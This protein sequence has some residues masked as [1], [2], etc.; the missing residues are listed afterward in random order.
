MQL[1][2]S[3]AFGEVCESWEKADESISLCKDTSQNLDADTVPLRSFIYA[4]HS[5]GFALFFLLQWLW[6][7]G[8][9]LIKAFYCHWEGLSARGS[10]SHL[11]CVRSRL[12]LIARCFLRMVRH[13]GRI[14]AATKMEKML[15]P[16]YIQ[17]HRCFGSHK[18]CEAYF[19]P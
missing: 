7:L 17:M 4:C 13:S 9:G 10:W 15:M 12:H 14:F 11:S 2:S 5:I 16:A 1:V 8:F 6:P 3:C 18:N 19:P